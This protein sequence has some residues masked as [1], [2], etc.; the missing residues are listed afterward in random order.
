MEYTFEVKTFDHQQ[1]ITTAHTPGF[2]WEFE[3]DKRAGIVTIEAETDEGY[4]RI[5]MPEAQWAQIVEA[6]A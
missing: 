2:E 6:M 5:T 3:H 1:H 4:K